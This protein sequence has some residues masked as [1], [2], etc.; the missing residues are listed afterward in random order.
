MSCIF[1]P[2]FLL[3]TKWI[4]MCSA[5]WGGFPLTLFFRMALSATAVYFCLASPNQANLSLN[6]SQPFSSSVCL[7]ITH[8]PCGHKFCEGETLVQQWWVTW[9]S[10]PSTSAAYICLLALPL[11]NPRCTASI[12]YRGLLGL[13]TW[14]LGRLDTTQIMMGSF[15]HMVTW[16]MLHLYQGQ[17]HARSYF[18]NGV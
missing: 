1:L 16:Q 18:S 2:Q 8:P 11:P 15:G 14:C 4:T 7:A 13:P 12:I 10:G 17:W 9:G 5:Q 3:H 6:Q